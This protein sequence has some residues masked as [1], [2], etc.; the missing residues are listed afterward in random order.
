M[1][2]PWPYKAVAH[3]PPRLVAAARPV[4]QDR[5]VRIGASE[6]RSFAAT[7]IVPHVNEDRDLDAGDERDEEWQLDPACRGY[8]GERERERHTHTHIKRERDT[9]RDVQRQRDSKKERD[10][11][12]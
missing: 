6:S 8:A 4:R 2:R 12:G 7:L 5:A 11:T 1:W 3:P 10:K 9:K